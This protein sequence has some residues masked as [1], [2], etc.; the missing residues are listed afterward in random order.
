[1][2]D[3]N[4]ERVQR[5]RI[6]KAYSQN[7][8]M[9]TLNSDLTNQRSFSKTG[10][11]FS[12]INATDDNNDDDQVYGNNKFDDQPGNQEMTPLNTDLQLKEESFGKSAVPFSL[13]NAASDDDSDSQV[14]GN[15][16]QSDGND[17]NDDVNSKE[18]DHDTI[19]LKKL[20]SLIKDTVKTKITNGTDDS[21]TEEEDEDDDEGNQSDVKTKSKIV[22][23]PKQFL[24]KTISFLNSSLANNS[25]VNST[26]EDTLNDNLTVEDEDPESKSNIAIPKKNHLDVPVEVFHA[27][28]GETRKNNSIGK[29]VITVGYGKDKSHQGKKNNLNRNGTTH[30]NRDTSSKKSN[31]KVR[32][33]HNNFQKKSQAIKGQIKEAEVKEEQNTKKGNVALSSGG[34]RV[35]E[36]EN[37]CNKES[38]QNNLKRKEIGEESGV[39]IPEFRRAST[40]T[41]PL[42]HTEVSYI[43][44]QETMSITKKESVE[45]SNSKEASQHVGIKAATENSIN[46]SMI[47]S[48]R[49]RKLKNSGKRKS[50][51]QQKKDKHKSHFRKE[52][53]GKP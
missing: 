41:S 27:N 23:F 35:D 12:V 19:N 30:R 43:P 37:E 49:S 21:N 20:G 2:Q 15:E 25:S 22:Q 36:K 48:S 26:G 38:A 52:Q 44:S 1:M 18:L 9:A 3:Y 29:F 32:K 39:D 33:A 13:I 6:G 16:Y 5:I 14:D 40:M 34:T 53:Y 8:G 24:N 11:P 45:K 28:N 51:L 7:Q 42:K 50:S 46:K 4:D 17:E 31:V 10:L 47:R